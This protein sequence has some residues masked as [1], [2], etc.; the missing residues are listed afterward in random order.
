MGISLYIYTAVIHSTVE[1]IWLISNLE[2]LQTGLL[3]TFICIYF[4]ECMYSF[5]CVTYLMATLL[6]HWACLYSA[7]EILANRFPKYFITIYTPINSAW[8]F[9]LSTSS[10]TLSI[11]YL[12]HFS[13]I[14]CQALIYNL[15]GNGKGK[16]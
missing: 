6:G 11:F 7:L 15:H 9:Q 1:D 2:L 10:T 8:V 14:D 5:Q 4:D 16:K 13:S 12:F 3:W